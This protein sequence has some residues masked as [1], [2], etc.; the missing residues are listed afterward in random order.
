MKV[1]VDTCVVIDHLHGIPEA[2]AYLQ[3]IE[4]GSL[5]GMVSLIT[6]T[7]LLA[8][9]KLSA[10]KRQAIEDLLSIFAEQVPVDAHIARRAADLLSAYRPGRG[11]DLADALIAATALVND[12][13]LLTR[14]ERHFN[15]I[16]GLLAV[17][18]LSAP[19]Q[20]PHAGER[21]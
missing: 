6:V 14:N 7:E 17:N 11:L 21:P 13:V 3:A 1:V 9:P 19:R 18:P 5:H 16:D 4:E 12:A 15:Y 8:A 2:T 20:Y 10:E